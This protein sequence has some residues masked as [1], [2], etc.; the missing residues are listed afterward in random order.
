MSQSSSPGRKSLPPSSRRDNEGNGGF[1]T[2]VQSNGKIHRIPQ[3]QFPWC[4]PTNEKARNTS[5][6]EKKD[7]SFPSY[8]KKQTYVFS[9][10]PTYNDDEQSD[11]GIDKSHENKTENVIV[12]YSGS[13]SFWR[14]G[15]V[16]DFKLIDH[17]DYS[18]IELI[19]RIS[20]ESI[21]APRYYF[22]TPALYS[23][24]DRERI[25]ERMKKKREMLLDLY[26]KTDCGLM[27]EYD[28]RESVLRDMVVDY[29]DQR[30]Y[31]PPEGDKFVIVFEFYISSSIFSEIDLFFIN[32]YYALY[33]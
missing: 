9:A 28:L 25:K 17:K 1:N 18:I 27:S 8:Y 15:I 4:K 2:V 26:F 7:D 19:L 30:L 21:N 10:A 14:S 29:I 32:F 6:V 31:V 5:K 3:L 11:D 23:K 24:F 22:S 13:K 20:A 16:V 33:S 12:F